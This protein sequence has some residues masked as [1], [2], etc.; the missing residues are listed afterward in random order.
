[1][2][3]SDVAASGDSP[4]DTGGRRA[5]RAGR[6]SDMLNTKRAGATAR[7]AASMLLAGTVARIT[8]ACGETS[9]QKATGTVSNRSCVGKGRGEGGARSS[10]RGTH[11]DDVVFRCAFRKVLHLEHIPG[12]RR[13]VGHRSGCGARDRA[14]DGVP[15]ADEGGG[16]QVGVVRRGTTADLRMH[17]ATSGTCVPA[18]AGYCL[19]VATLGV[20]WFLSLPM[21]HGSNQGSK[22]ASKHR[23]IYRTTLSRHSHTR[24]PI[25]PRGAYSVCF[26][27]QPMCTC[28]AACIVRN[29]PCCRCA[30]EG[31]LAPTPH[32]GHH[33]HAPARHA[34][35]VQQHTSPWLIEEKDRHRQRSRG[36]APGPSPPRSRSGCRSRTCGPPTRRRASCSTDRPR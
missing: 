28:M 18:A 17:A 7:V 32:Q 23:S 36:A 33:C 31:S 3:C 1:M 11:L 5:G 20:G 35:A 29:P 16:Q 12:R 15:R 30:S 14:A 9:L 22:Q 26:P 4:R 13:R 10:L 27:L 21:G 8:C 34:A 19:R 25:Q 6:E 24:C 2:H